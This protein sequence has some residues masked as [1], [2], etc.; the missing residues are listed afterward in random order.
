MKRKKKSI[1]DLILSDPGDVDLK[2]LTITLVSTVLSG[3]VSFVAL[4]ITS[5]NIWFNS[6]GCFTGPTAMYILI[7]GASLFAVLALAAFLN[8]YIWSDGLNG[9]VPPKYYGVLFDR[10][11]SNYGPPFVPSLELQLGFY[12]HLGGVFSSVLGFAFA[13]RLASKLLAARPVRK[14]R[15]PLKNRS[16]RIAVAKKTGFCDGRNGN[17]KTAAT[18]LTE[19]EPTGGSPADEELD[20]KQDGD[21]PDDL[22]LLDATESKI[23]TIII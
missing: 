2:E 7:F 21:S 6:K 4:F 10:D 9:I 22:V 1:F 20:G 12:I 8:L 5:I 18:E 3:C 15:D 14:S 11:P 17:G 16:T 13:C 19:L 23:V